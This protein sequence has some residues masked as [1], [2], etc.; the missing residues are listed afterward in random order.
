M[1]DKLTNKEA[2]EFVKKV[3]EPFKSLPHL[4]EGLVEFFVK[5]APWLAII[6]AVLGLIS[7]PITGLIGGLASL[8]TLQPMYLVW[9]VLSAILALFNSV[10][11]FY[12]FNPLKGREMKGWMLL[13]WSNLVGVATGVLALVWGSSGSSY[14][15]TLLGIVIG[16]YVLF[17][18]KPFYDG[19]VVGEVVRAKSKKK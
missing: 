13:F 2:M 18:M 11:L 9:T 14:V 1:F 4:P 5:V 3:Q 6:G 12:A 17:E 10:L 19:V 8:F 7:A 15:G 16:L